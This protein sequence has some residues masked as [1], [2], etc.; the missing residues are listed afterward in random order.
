M[1]DYLVNLNDFSKLSFIKEMKKYADCNNVP[2]ISEEGLSLILLIIR[3]TNSKRILELGT[4]I[5]YSACNMALASSDIIIDTIERNDLMIDMAK[6]NV[7]DLNL[8]SQIN[9]LKGDALE[10]DVDNLLNTYD[11]IFIDAAKAQYRKFFE[12]YEKK[13][14]SHGVIICDNLNFHGLVEQEKIIGSKSLQALVKK[15]K[16]FNE[17]LKCNP[18]YNSFFMNIG[19]GM[20]VSMKKE[21]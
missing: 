16:S 4:A 6:K 20:S 13:L 15:I 17:W 1:A 8:S 5:G 14:N 19:D 2:I 21:E 18:Y 11:V 9:I 10:Y 3:L 7:Q 12:K